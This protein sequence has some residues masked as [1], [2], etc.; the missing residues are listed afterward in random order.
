MPSETHFLLMYDYVEDILERRAP[1]R[2]AH[3]G[4]L[5]RLKQDGRVLMAG[6]LGDPVT[7][8][9]IVFA[10]CA[11]EEV[12]EYVLRDPYYEAGL[13]TDWR[14]IPWNVVI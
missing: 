12:G 4:R 8:A 6:A 11:P 3:L 7:G 13:I 1:Y 5:T 2:E 10:P 9:A 14:A